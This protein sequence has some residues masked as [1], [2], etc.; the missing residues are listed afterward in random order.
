MITPVNIPIQV[1][2]NGAA[3]L[4]LQFK[5][6]NVARDLTG[7]QVRAYIADDCEAQNPKVLGVIEVTIVDAVEGRIRLDITPAVS[8]KLP[9]SCFYD[10]LIVPGSGLNEYWVRGTITVLPSVTR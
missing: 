10:V 1:I 3:D 7:V 8:R 6:D 2:R 5:F 4:Q 9:D